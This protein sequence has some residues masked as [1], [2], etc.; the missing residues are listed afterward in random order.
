[1]PSDDLVAACGNEQTAGV[2]VG[3]VDEDLVVDPV[4][5]RALGTSISLNGSNPRSSVRRETFKVLATSVSEAV[6][7]T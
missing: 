2:G 5:V 3:A 7:V 1:M 6:P 4:R